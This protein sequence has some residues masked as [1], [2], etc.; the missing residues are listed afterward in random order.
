VSGPSP[1]DLARQL[2][3]AWANAVAVPAPSQQDP[4][5]TVEDA[6]RIQELIVAERIQD[7]RRRAGWK[8]GLT[9]SDPPAPIVGT[10]LSDMLLPSGVDLAI[11]TMVAPMV[12]AE[13]VVR[14]GETI[15]GGQTLDELRR[16]PHEI[17][18]GIEV[19]D[20][21][22]VDSTGPVDWIADNST[23]AYGVV[24]DFVPLGEIDAAELEAKLFAGDQFLAS[25]AGRQVMGDPL[26]AVAWLSD[27]LAARSQPL[28]RRQVVLTGSLTGHH[29]VPAG[30]D[31]E[32]TADFGILGTVSIG[33][34]G[35]HDTSTPD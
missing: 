3:E 20:Y 24:G 12:E 2:S 1:E 10:L 30:Q 35:P 19:I 26:A 14:I 33:F 23:V 27:H 8:L 28:E 31:S 15:Y 25:G 13:L 5:M 16:G 17:G 34:K 29:A 21:R 9:T 18:P 7:G 32:F 11:S 22:T 4:S 6:Y